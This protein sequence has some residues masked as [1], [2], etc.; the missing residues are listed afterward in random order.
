MIRMQQELKDNITFYV[1]NDYTLEKALDGVNIETFSD[2]TIEFLNRLSLAISEDNRLKKYSDVQTFAFWCRKASILNM[3][4]SY[5][6]MSGRFGRGL[7]FHIAPSNIPMMCMFSLAVSLLAGNMNI[8][9]LSSREFEQTKLI[10]EVLSKVLENEKDEIR[11][12]VNIINYPHYRDITDFFSV[13][14]DSRIIWGG[15]NSVCE[16]RKSPLAP[17]G[18]DIPFY[19][20]FSFAVIDAE[21]YCKADNKRKIASD[22]Y[23]DTYFTDQNACT[24]PQLVVW[25]GDDEVIGKAKKQFWDI[26]EDTIN[27]NYKFA[28]IQGVDKISEVCRYSIKYGDARA[29]TDNLSLVRMVVNE[30]HSDLCDFRC[31]GGYFYEYHTQNLGDIAIVSQKKAQTIAVYGVDRQELLEV[32]RDSKCRGVDRIVP[33]GRT[34]DFGLKWDGFDFIYSLSRIIG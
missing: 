23:N 7:T 1:G 25:I 13:N 4:K 10:C 6:D 33:I 2:G 17:Y 5:G 26:L 16:I 21:K 29:Y 8:L 18:I 11:N 12:A 3:K 30:L 34:M 28:D 27:Q 14:C 32:I 31:P 20:R 19:D 24:S 15:D 22:F 9:R